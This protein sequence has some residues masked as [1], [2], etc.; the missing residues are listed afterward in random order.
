[1]AGYREVSPSGAP[2]AF[3][4][5][6]RLVVLTGRKARDLRELLC[7]LRQVSGSS[8]FYHTHYLYLI[9]HF[10]K[11][12][13]YN[14]FAEWVS[15][16]LQEKRLAEQLAAIDLLS[17][18]SIQQIREA[19]IALIEKHIGN[20]TQIE[21]VCPQDDEFH[22]CEAKSFIM[23]TGLVAHDVPEFFQQVAHVSN[24]CLHFHIFEARLRL[25]RPTNDFSQWL[26]SLGEARLAREID[27]LH[28][29]VMTLDELKEEIVK[30]GKKHVRRPW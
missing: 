6:R 27:R 7:H 23:P 13:F 17:I 8:V 12:K 18:T 3:Y 11:P 22:F 5:E 4:T 21:R 15:E 24:S 14:E 29:Y 19:L 25:G 28:P 26:Q 10:E 20:G 16:A 30:I 1:M 9:H 2:L